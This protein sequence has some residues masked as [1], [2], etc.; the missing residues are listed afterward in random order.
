MKPVD[1]NY[2]KTWFDTQEELDDYRKHLEKQ[3]G[4][5]VYFTVKDFEDGI[6]EVHK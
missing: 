1:Y 4:C 3:I 6:G 2:K 5:K